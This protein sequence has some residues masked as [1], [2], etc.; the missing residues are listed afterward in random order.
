M[1]IQSAMDKA[2]KIQSSDFWEEIYAIFQED[3]GRNFESKKEE[4]MAMLEKKA[5]KLGLELEKVEEETTEAQAFHEKFWDKGIIPIPVVNGVMRKVSDADYDNYIALQNENPVNAR[6]LKDE[7]SREYYWNDHINANALMC[8]IIINEEYVG[9]CG[10]K[11]INKECWEIAVELFGKNQRKGIGRAAMT[12]FLDSIKERTGVDEFRI[13]IFADNYASQALFEKLGAVPNGTSTF[14]LHD[15]ES[16]RKC[17]EDNMHLIDE[18]IC[19]VAKKFSVEPR[20]LL[21]HVL[22]YKLCW[23]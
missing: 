18:Q 16:I 21:S 2:S 6:L 7:K 20:C 11:D 1:N 8:S 12:S 10:I 9:Y 14:W 19:M 13:R 23:R 15:E 4:V 3:D 17:E 5:K 22:E